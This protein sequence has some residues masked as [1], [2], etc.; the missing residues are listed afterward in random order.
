MR[1]VPLRE[2]SAQ[3]DRLAG[4]EALEQSLDRYIERPSP[5]REFL[6]ER[7]RQT[8]WWTIS[9]L[10]HL[11]ALLILWQWPVTARVE[12]PLGER[13]IIG[14]FVRDLEKQKPPV[15]KPPV[16]PPDPTVIPPDFEISKN[17]LNTTPPDERPIELAPRPGP[18]L[19]MEPI[20]P[21]KQQ[22]APDIFRIVN[23]HFD[24]PRDRNSLK[25][26]YGI[27]D[28]LGDG[29]GEDG[30]V[31]NPPIVLPPIL[32]ALYWLQQAQEKDGSWDAKRWDGA[33][34]YRVGMTGL[35]LLAYQG[36]GFTHRQGRFS[37]TIL[38]ALNWLRKNQRPD[39]S[40]PWETFYEQGIA[41]MA[42]C[43]AYAMTE[44]AHL[45]PMAQ[46]AI[47]YICKIQPEH[48]GFR[49]GGAVPKGE[50]DM[51]VTGWQIMAI[52]S[53]LLAKLNVPPAAVERSHEFLKNSARDYGASSYLAGDKAAGSLAV[54]SI[55][56]L[57]RIFISEKGQYEGEIRNTA[58]FLYGREVQD[59]KPVPG[60]VSKQ[61]VTDL[62]YTYYSS[63]AMFQMG[64]EY[65]RGWNLMYRDPLIDLQVKAK[66][67][68]GGRY[69]KGSW[70]PG[71]HRWGSRGGRVYSTAMAV[72]CLEAPFR[73]LPLLRER[74]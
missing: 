46:E 43:E 17:I 19:P 71:R 59:L 25:R 57:C 32:A 21:P 4:A 70:E 5:L 61:L 10:V 3:T 23:A 27:R 56:M 28:G 69:V 16:P 53:A 55:G 66:F 50:G 72:L 36:A 45:R 2:G 8:P 64:G 9:F 67:D 38:R 42:V 63:L 39:G 24:V 15:E 29:S 37:E 22:L 33:A 40:F 6:A 30:K 48:G 26:R 58:E 18:L 52:K 34:P 62:Y 60:G 49:Y 44:D 7:L 54:T 20:Q 65:W 35:A 31:G 74:P 13:V 14:D 1:H 41:T 68:A 51:S 12:E 47:G 73:F 11:I